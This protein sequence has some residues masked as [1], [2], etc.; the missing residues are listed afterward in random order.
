MELSTERAQFA[1]IVNRLSLLIFVNKGNL[2]KWEHSFALL[3]QRVK[4]VEFIF[5]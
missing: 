4:M 5:P 3:L 1:H 2:V